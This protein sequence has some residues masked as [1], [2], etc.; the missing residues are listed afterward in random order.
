MET[1]FSPCTN[2]ISAIKL[3]KM[4]IVMWIGEGEASKMGDKQRIESNVDRSTL[5]LPTQ[6]PEHC[7][8]I[9][10]GLAKCQE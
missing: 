5:Q 8:C 3:I 10:N 1:A 2:V 7:E 9:V 6:S 4:Y